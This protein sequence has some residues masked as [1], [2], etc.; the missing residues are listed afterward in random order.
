M[1]KLNQLPVYV[2]VQLKNPD[3][4]REMWLDLPVTKA[5]FAAAL[6]TINSEDGNVRVTDYFAYGT[7]LTSNEAMV[8]PLSVMNYLAA[9]LRKLTPEEILKLR[10][11]SESEH[12]FCQ[13]GQVIDYTFATY[14]Y[15]LLPNITDAEKLGY[16]HLGAPDSSFGDPAWRPVS[17]YEYGLKLAESQGGVFT[18]QGYLTSKNGWDPLNEFRAVP[19]S[20]NLRGSLNEDL[21]G[22]FEN[23]DFSA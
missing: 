12:Y 7:G 2:A 23:Y 13:A 5:K 16:Y 17:R 11:I 9:R 4:S 20:L 6:T 15:K 14:K 1:K 22:D 19:G 18:P 10:A 3:C 21:Y 8:T